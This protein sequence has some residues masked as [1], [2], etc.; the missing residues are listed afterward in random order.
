[1]SLFA[2]LKKIERE[3]NSNPFFRFP[4][5]RSVEKPEASYQR[6]LQDFSRGRFEEYHGGLI[7]F[8]AMRT[9]RTPEEYEQDFLEVCGK[10]AFRTHFKREPSDG[11][12][13]QM[14]VMRGS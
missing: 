7:C 8:I 13:N 4:P 1:M 5:T 12:L 3:A 6:M 2:R 14:S 9:N 11:H 10:D